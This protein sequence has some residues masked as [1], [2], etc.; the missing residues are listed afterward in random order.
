MMAHVNQTISNKLACDSLLAYQVS[1]QYVQSWADNEWI[2]HIAHNRVHFIVDYIIIYALTI[3]KL[4]VLL[5]L[6]FLKLTNNQVFVALHSVSLYNKQ[7][8]SRVD[9]KVNK[10]NHDTSF[11]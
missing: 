11:S 10:T 6:Y 9:L 3:L 8:V 4:N 2:S 5:L 7:M 1:F